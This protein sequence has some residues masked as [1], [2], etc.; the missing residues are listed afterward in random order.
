MSAFNGSDQPTM[1]A[2]GLRR[3]SHSTAVPTI[4]ASLDVQVDSTESQRAEAERRGHQDGYA[5]G[6]ARALAETELTRQEESQ[7]VAT[8]L[9]AL[10]RAVVVVQEANVRLRS[11]IQ[12]AAPGLA[13]ALLEQLLARELEVAVNPGREALVRALAMD[14]GTTPATV[15]MNPRDVEQL[16]DV[17]ALNLG[18]EVQVVPD[19]TIEVGGVLVEIG[20]VTLDG[21]LS[22]ALERVRSVLVVGGGLGVSDDRAA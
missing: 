16:G 21:Q 3:L 20:D 6:L 15:R 12:T 13:F 1:L 4:Y 2:R 5:E 22:T 9:E 19:S 7:R 11:E 17:A 10:A 14:E 18:R 8:A